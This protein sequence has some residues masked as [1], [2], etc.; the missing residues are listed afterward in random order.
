[1]RRLVLSLAVLILSAASALT[2]TGAAPQTARQALL[3]MFFSK[4]PGTLLKHLPVIT[5]AALEK[6]G[7]LASLQQ[8][9]LLTAQF[10]TQGN[11]FETFETGPI[12]LAGTDPKTGQKTEITVVNDAM[13]GD[14]DDIELSFRVY[15]NGEAQRTPYMPQFTFSMK[16]E[17]QIWKL[18]EV[19]LTLHLP[20]A[21]PDLLKAFSE[22]MQASAQAQAHATFTPR[23][24]ISATPSGSDTTVVTAMRSIL[25]AETTYA[26]RY[27]SVGYTCTLSNLDGFGDGEPNEHH[28]M[29]L[30]SGLASGKRFG[31]VFSLSECT[32]TPTAGFH[33]TAVP[34]VNSFGRKA[35]CS[36]QAGN[37]RISE[38]GNPATCMTRGTPLSDASGV[39][40]RDE[41]SH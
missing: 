6:S 11:N 10:Q 33:L 9:S 21:D 18:N 37:I 4:T 22:K 24:E 17:A 8:Y 15:K 23:T 32:G 25:A 7:A 2:Q 38:D 40:R 16:Q 35:F 29:I 19:S 27:P 12:L 34:N 39:A 20:L 41:A 5:R 13:H 28:A 36:D 30:E 14:Q 3:E 26:S 31:F 1:M